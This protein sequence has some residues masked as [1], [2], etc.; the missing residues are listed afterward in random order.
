M[1]TQLNHIKYKIKCNFVDTTIALLNP[2]NLFVI[3]FRRQREVEDR[4]KFLFSLKYQN[5]Y[6][7]QSFRA[8]KNQIQPIKQPT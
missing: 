1:V 4:L 3:L 5:K 6:F 2:N 8:F 7:N